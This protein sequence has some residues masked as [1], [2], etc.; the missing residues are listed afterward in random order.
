MLVLCCVV[1]CQPEISSCVPGAVVDCPCAGGR[2]GTQTCSGAG[3]WGACS[4]EPP[5]DGGVDECGPCERD[6]ECTG[7]TTLRRYHGACS[8]GACVFEAMDTYCPAG[9]AAGECVEGTC[10]GVVCDEPPPDECVGATTLRTYG[11]ACVDGACVYAP[12]ESECAVGCADGVCLAGGAPPVIES[13]A[14]SA[15]TLNED[16]A[17]ILTA[18]IRDPEGDDTI[19]NGLAIDPASEAFIAAF[20]LVSPGSYRAT[21]SWAALHAADDITFLDEETREIEVRFFDSEG[22]MASR[23]ISIALSCTSAEPPVAACGGVCNGHLDCGDG[24]ISRHFDNANCGACGRACEHGSSVSYCFG[25]ECACADAGDLQCGPRGCRSAFEP[26]SCGSCGHSCA[27]DEICGAGGVCHPPEEGAA[28][29]G[30]DRVFQAFTGGVWQN[31]CVRERDAI[32]VGLLCGALGLDGQGSPL[33]T[34]V[35]ACPPE[36]PTWVALTCYPLP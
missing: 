36:S 10:A 7:S 23:R 30:P 22:H 8:E 24:C 34:P 16:E 6:A 26:A 9:C 32:T 5:A 3:A 4:C 29:V 17:L 12:S 11:G 33:E 14:A 21:I 25:G 15:E 35:G 20:A 18:T 19:R 31:V 28:R 2:S 27:P 13:L 1:G